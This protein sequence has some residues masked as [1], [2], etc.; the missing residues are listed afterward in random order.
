VD[1]QPQRG[2]LP[3]AGANVVFHLAGTVGCGRQARTHTPRVILS[4][5]SLGQGRLTQGRKDALMLSR[6][7]GVQSVVRGQ[8]NGLPA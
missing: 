8:F 1:W 4:G 6:Q 2:V 5:D 7:M 3:C